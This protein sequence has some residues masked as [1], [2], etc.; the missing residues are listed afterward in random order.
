MTKQG[1]KHLLGILLQL[2]VTGAALWFV[3]HDPQKRGQ[4]AEALRHADWRWLAAG[5]G[6]YGLVE[7]L[8]IMR[9]QLLIQ[10][11]GFRIPWRRSAAILLISEFFLTF[12]PGLVGGDAMRVVYLVKDHPDKKVDAF[13]AVVMDRIMGML[14]LISIAAVVLTARYHWLSQSPA[15]AKLIKVVALILG[16]GAAA[17]IVSVLIARFGARANWPIPEKLKELG[18]A[19]KQFGHDKTRTIASFLTTLVSHGFYY[20]SFCCAARALGNLS[21]PAPAAWDVFSVMPIENTLTA[22]PISFAGIGLRETLFQT[23]LNELSGVPTAMGALIGSIGF[24]TKTLWGLPGAVI[25]VC[26][27]FARKAPAR[28]DG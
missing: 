18:E 26:Y 3:F 21:K 10:I 13:T 15:A 7:V 6:L 2:A 28:Q 20:A 19:F 14:A 5:L 1:A 8:A 27:R 11:Q 17:L 9:W 4:M 25:F 12:T 24:V 23:L 22:L 16:A